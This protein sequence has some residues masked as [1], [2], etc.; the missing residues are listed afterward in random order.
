[1][2]ARFNNVI[3]IIISPENFATREIASLISA[4]ANSMWPRTM[5]AI[6]SPIEVTMEIKLGS[7]SLLMTLSLLG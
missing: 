3:T 2:P 4:C 1:M 6:S 7:R 5:A